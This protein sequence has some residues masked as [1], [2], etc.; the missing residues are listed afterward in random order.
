MILCKS[1]NFENPD[2]LEFCDRCHSPLYGRDDAE[3]SGNA[4]IFNK[5]GIGQVIGM[6]YV[7]IN[8]AADFS[9]GDV[10]DAE[11]AADDSVVSL[12]V[13]PNYLSDDEAAVERLRAA[14]GKVVGLSHENLLGLLD[15][16][17]EDERKFLVH[18]KTDGSPLSDKIALSPLSVEECLGIFTR[19][20]EAL[21]YVHSK[22]VIHGDVEPANIFP[23]DNGGVKLLF[24]A[25]SAI[26]KDASAVTGGSEIFRAAE[27]IAGKTV[28]RSDI[29]SFAACIY[30][31]LGGYLEDGRFSSLGILSEGQN[32]AL[33]NALGED[34]LCRQSTCGELLKDLG[35][36]ITSLQWKTTQLF[37][38]SISGGDDG[39]VFLPTRPNAKYD[40]ETEIQIKAVANDHYHFAGWTGSAVR[41]G[42]VEDEKSAVTKL[43]VDADYTLIAEFAI[44]QHEVVMSCSEGGVVVSPQEGACKYDYGCEVELNGQA[45]EN[46]HFVKW[47]GTAVENGYVA[48]PD[49]PVTT[50]T[51]EGD[52]AVH[53]EFAVDTFILSMSCGQGGVVRTDEDDVTVDLPVSSEYAY[54]SEVVVAAE[55]EDNY[56]FVEWGGSAVD[57]GMVDDPARAETKLTVVGECT[58]NAVFVVNSHELKLSASGGGMILEP[59]ESERK[60]NH[61]I[62]L[63]VRAVADDHCHFVEWIGSA[64][65]AGKVADPFDPVTVL[66]VDG[67]YS[68]EAVF[69][70]DRFAFDMSASEGGEAFV[71][72]V[73]DEVAGYEYGSTVTIV[74]RAQENYHFVEW[75]GAAVDG[76]N[77]EES[78][79]ERTTVKVEG[80]YA[81]CAVFEIDNHVLSLSS[82]SG[83]CVVEPFEGFSEISHGSEVL[84]KA[85]AD[86]NYHFVNW[87]GSAVD[88]GKVEDVANPVVSLEVDDDCS[89]E[90]VFAIDRYSFKLEQSDGGS[91]TTD[92]AEAGDYEHGSRVMVTATADENFHFVEWA[93]SAV[94]ARKVKAL[95]SKRTMVTVDGEYTLRAVFALDRH[96]LNLSSVGGG[97]VTEP[98]EGYSEYDHGREVVV[99]ALADENHHFVE[100]S[101]AGV[102]EDKLADKCSAETTI[103]IDGDVS[104]EA[105]FAIDQ[106]CLRL[107]S[108]RAGTAGTVDDYLDSYIYG[109]K[110]GIVALADENYHFVEWVGSA[111]DNGWVADAKSAETTVTV[112][113]DIEV[114]AVFA[115]DEKT[116]T[117]CSDD[118]GLVTLPGCGKF[119]HDY[120]EQVVIECYANEK[121]HFVGWAGSAVDNGKVADPESPKTTV[122]LEGDYEVKAIFE[123]DKFIIKALEFVKKFLEE[124]KGKA[125]AAGI[126]IGVL[127]ISLIAGVMNS[128][129]EDAILSGVLQDAQSRAKAGD[130]DSAILLADRIIGS[131]E[132]FA[133]DKNVGEM[134]AAWEKELK[135]QKIWIE[136]E[137][138]ESQSKYEAAFVKANKLVRDYP[139]TSFAEKASKK[140]EELKE[141]IAIDNQISK[142][143]DL[144]NSGDLDKAEAELNG[145]FK[146]SPGNASAALVKMQIDE[147]VKAKAEKLKKGLL[148]S[149]L[150]FVNN[151]DWDKAISH[152]SQALEMSPRDEDIKGKLA[153]AYMAQ[154]DIAEEKKDYHAAIEFY[155]LAKSVK[156]SDV[157][158][159]KLLL[160]GNAFKAQALGNAT[161][162]ARAA[163]QAESLNKLL[164]LAEGVRKAGEY[165]VAVKI[166]ETIRDHYPSAEGIDGK[167]AETKD[168]YA[169]ERHDMNFSRAM[170]LKNTGRFQDAQA[171]L[172]FFREALVCKEVESTQKEMD[173]LIAAMV[174]IQEAES[175]RQE[176]ANYLQDAKEAKEK[177]DALE[178]FKAHEKAAKA[179][180]VEAMAAVG[181]A[182]YD[183]DG[184]EKDHV[185]AVEWFKKAAEAGYGPVYSH[186]GFAYAEGNGK[187]RN[188]PM[189]FECF[190][191]GADSGCGLS[192]YYLSKA[193]LDGAGVKKDVDQAVSWCEKAANAGSAQAAFELGVMYEEGKGV[194]KDEYE[195]V[196][197]YQ[198][199]ARLGND[200]AKDRLVEMSEI[201]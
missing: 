121:Y 26:I 20:G 15:V 159:E 200:E 134:K 127:F 164:K 63:P 98:G 118:G 65:D 130:F 18:E 95:F 156:P 40:P 110:V 142:A 59:G 137:L 191:K 146:K 173:S 107:S 132:D 10:F 183:G 47:S 97:S 3:V 49:S 103:V 160:A 161:V 53:A 108:G 51:V 44:D 55:A 31:S 119:S 150:R 16:E 198:K 43:V 27:Q 147:K 158:G 165:A 24:P 179:G 22:G 33:R 117:V 12:S 190:K 48:E 100:W 131:S 56:T 83:G 36:D 87:T 140:A 182:L 4:N 29:Y 138:L 192:M 9:F 94:D 196:R 187:Q 58:L 25:V 135:A 111:V 184:V 67:D 188:L 174:K 96:V 112:E 66:K 106:H 145:V 177:G 170:S 39:Q 2:G 186:L 84:V 91:M 151:E 17:L 74:A 120:G 45:E 126:V 101:V 162:Q 34:T 70:V 99:K 154:A 57:D 148:N 144:M 197:W 32:T 166:Y 168:Q 136:V 178:V 163:A 61:G 82:S 133:E 75:T 176:I 21:D 73:D 152:Y 114:E 54:G 185:K 19:V 90:A 28:R 7:I 93:G 72:G 77:V 129:N 88:N 155:L 105:V 60:F 62:E 180:S 46:Q 139:D 149:A 189:A 141:I 199:A 42:K 102:D 11:D 76:G 13:L 81:L 128:S 195:S 5:F 193:Y 92:D 30:I 79:L 80:D 78:S 181:V 124:P 104:L 125:I 201:W 157:I 167:L 86:R 50:L 68:L 71:E 89:L 123:K 38:V 169:T 85:K 23:D 122:L 8:D 172:V 64:V 14:A 69:E 143:R 109:R 175:K 6:R 41:A 35:V 153:E 115:I 116:L 37:N 194:K 1:C 52:C 171:A 113:G